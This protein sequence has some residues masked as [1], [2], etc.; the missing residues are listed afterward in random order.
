M[1]RMQLMWVAA[2]AAG[3]LWAQGPAAA[4]K[5]AAAAAKKEAPPPPTAPRPFEFP[6]HEKKVLSNGLTV[7]FVEDHRLPQVTYSMQI[8]GAGNAAD[9]PEKAGLAGFTA[10]LLREGTATRNSQQISKLVDTAGGSLGASASDDAASVS[11][12]FMKA[13]ADLGIELMADITLNPKFA[14]D[15]IDRQMRQAQSSLAVSYNDPEYLAPLLAARGILGT[16]PYAYPGS[17]TPQ[18]LRNI[19]REDIA[20][21]HARHYAP[22]R[23]YLAIAGDLT[24]AEAFAKAEK[25]FGA[26]KTPAPPEQ[27][28]PPPPAAAAKVLILDKPDSNQTQIV[29]GHPGVQR[30]HP[31][32]LALNVANQ[33]FGGSFNSRLNMKLRANEGLTYGAG[34]SF[35]PQRQAGMFTA[36]T[37]TR[38]EKTADAI[39]FMVDLLKEFK[40]NPATPQEFEEAKNF[41]IG[42]FGL[43]LERSADVASRVLATA[44]NDLPESYYSTYRGLLQA[45][46]REQVIA[47]VQKHLQPEKLMIATVGNSKEYAKAL[48]VYGP[49]TTIA[50]A[51]LDLVADNLL[52]KKET[53]VASAAGAAKAKALIDAAAGAMGGRDKI[54][55]VKDLF[56]KGPMKLTT[57]QG[58]LEAAVDEFV[59]FPDKYK[60]VMTLG[61][62]GQMVQSFDGKAGYMMQ[63][64]MTQDAPPQFHDEFRKGILT[65]CGIG[66][67]AAALEGKAETQALDDNTVQWKM[68]AIEIK[69]AF[70]PN[71]R[72]I[73]KLSYRGVGM[74]GM[75]ETDNLLSDYRE[76]AGLKLPFKE[77]VLQ[78]GQPFGDRTVT[79]RK[80]NSGLDPS[81]FAK[82]AK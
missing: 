79:E 27:K 54:L 22:A 29:M 68:G 40:A 19:K 39:K 76:V 58:N 56:S 14:Q 81:V 13:Y 42:V 57:P 71:T 10:A 26:W 12:S 36:S 8:L 38:T 37:F 44:V 49:A 70:D 45:L 6:K 33:I 2:L 51:D 41:L 18:T 16:H 4:P 30:N 3:T 73:S 63:G 67:L 64:P 60:L 24:P 28:L 66:L 78:N 32:Y 17:G 25:H 5:P 23:A 80:V 65:A 50:I 74:G 7:Y 31:D 75:A 20:G 53:V 62:M 43:S 47:A 69:M 9:Q 72:L 46:T 11:A 1:K 35:S 52:R 77:V 82:P 15:E 48:E 61:S 55:G 59:V 34:S 21:F